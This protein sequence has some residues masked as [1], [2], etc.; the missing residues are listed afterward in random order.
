MLLA[1]GFSLLVLFFQK[2][3]GS[4]LLFFTVFV[5]MLWIATQRASY[6]VVGGTLFSAGAYFAWR[7]VRPRPGRG[8]TSG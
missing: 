3:L 6:L 5:V 8:S 2:D 1:W 4:S 7:I